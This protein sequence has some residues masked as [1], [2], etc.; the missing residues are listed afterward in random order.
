MIGEYDVAPGAPAWRWRTDY[1][2]LD[3]DHLVITA[4]N[5]SP[6][7]DETKA[8]ETEY[9]RTPEAKEG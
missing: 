1:E 2:L 4:Y 3:D 6:E 5:I 7:G 9:V 8:M